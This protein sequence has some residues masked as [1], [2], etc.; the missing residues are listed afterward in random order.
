MHTH[1]P[2]YLSHPATHL[3]LGPGKASVPSCRLCCSVP[4]VL[5]LN[6]LPSCRTEQQL[7]G[8]K[9]FMSSCGKVFVTPFH[10]FSSKLVDYL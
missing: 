3:F 9:A 2:T 10:M 8:S 1:M 7:L 6:R 5:L 4:I